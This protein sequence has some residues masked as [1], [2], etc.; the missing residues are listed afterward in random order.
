M[1]PAT[2]AYILPSGTTDYHDCCRPSFPMEGFLMFIGTW[3]S[4]LTNKFDLKF[5]FSAVRLCCVRQIMA[6]LSELITS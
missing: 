1:K 3:D 6:F 2:G 5:A 4:R